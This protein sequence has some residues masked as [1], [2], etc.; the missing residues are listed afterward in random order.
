MADLPKDL[1]PDKPLFANVGV[2]YFG[3]FD[4]KRGCSLVK[5]YCVIFTCL[6]FRAVH[7]KVAHS[8]DVD[9]CINA[10]HYFI[11]RR[12]Q[13]AVI[14]SDNGINFVVVER[15]LREATEKLNLSKIHDAV[16][17]KG[18]K[19]IFNPPA[20]SHHGGAWERQI[21]TVR[22]ILCSVLKQQIMDDEGLQNVLCEVESIINDRPTTKTSDD[23]IDF[24]APQATCCY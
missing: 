14:G 10:L 9:A 16:M 8:L 6:T 19:W 24:E 23:P 2:D 12:R 1:L 4:V 21:H 3:S 13:V 20:A 17:Q 18:I 5:W 11:S 22:K 7:I 15:G